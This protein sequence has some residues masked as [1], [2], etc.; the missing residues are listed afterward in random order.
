MPTFRPNTLYYGDNLT[1]LR[2]FPAEC[3]D[4][5]YLDPPF[6]SNRSYNVL[7]KEDTGREAE[8]QVQAFEDTW[9]WGQA[10]SATHET[11]N[12]FVAR[13]TDDARLLE[14][15]VKSLGRNDV[16]AYLT[17]MA[18]RLVE[19]RRVLKPTGSIYLH[20]DPTAGHYLKV[21]M[22]AVF[23]AVNFRNEIIWKRTTAHS[24]TGQGARH[25]GRI[26]DVLLFYGRS[27]ASNW[28]HQ[29]TPYEK[30]YA[31]RY[32]K[33]L[34][35]S[36][37]RYWRDNLTAA[38]PGGDTRY[39]WKGKLPPQGRYWAFSKTNM[40]RLEKEGRIV[41]SSTGTPMY[42]RFLDEMPGRPVQD[43]WTDIRGLGGLG[44]KQT[45]RLGYATQKP[46][47]LLERIIESS[48][49]PDDVVLDPFCGCGTAVVAAH[50]LKAKR[51]WIGIDVAMVAVNVMRNRLK[52]TFPDDFPGE[53]HVDGEPADEA[54]ALDLAAREKY[55]FQNWVV[56]KLGGLPR[57]G[58]FKKG[59]DREVDGIVTFPDFDPNGAGRNDVKIRRI[60]VQVKGGAASPTD[61]RALVT[62]VEQEGAVIGV[63]VWIRNPTP[64]MVRVAAEAGLY[65]SPSTGK[66]YP[67]IQI[68]TAGEIARPLPH[69][70]RI[71][72]PPK[73]GLT[74][75]QPAPRA[76]RGNQLMISEMTTPYVVDSVK[77]DPAEPDSDNQDDEA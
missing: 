67:K 6:N 43:L 47:A 56:D 54:A 62:A 44:S 73:R 39:E 15:L 32:Y 52:T 70:K 20:C 46:E 34:D 42:K 16:T 68:L 60:I 1:I 29:Y 18:P 33:Y 50:K 61:V 17:M 59:R 53:I 38:K 10:N 25:F 30:E 51:R 76:K 7:F 35:D 64:E 2:D 14:A 22:D 21:L 4:L 58:R 37:R 66:T 77:S 8:A 27:E 26:H 40:E 72:M 63:F 5:I 31:D 9:H 11:Y 13:G 74:Q 65:I 12:Q 57:S 48:S 55:D 19:L 75:Y 36:G 45:E 28:N 69:G 41:Y 3:V 71:D 23:G 24:D 49:D